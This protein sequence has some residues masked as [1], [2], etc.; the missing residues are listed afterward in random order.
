M[1]VKCEMPIKVAC[2]ALCVLA[3]NPGLFSQSDAT[4]KCFIVLTRSLQR[5]HSAMVVACGICILE[6]GRRVLTIGNKHYE[7][8]GIYSPKGVKDITGLLDKGIKSGEEV[9]IWY[10]VVQ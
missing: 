9:G 5:L 1:L 8:A 6:D 7:L 2:H 3:R 10:Q 4:A